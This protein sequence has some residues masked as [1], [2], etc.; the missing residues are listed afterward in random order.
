MIGGRR[1]RG[2]PGQVVQNSLCTLAHVTSDLV[3]HALVAGIQKLRRFV[4]S[5][6]KRRICIMTSLL[7]GLAIFALRHLGSDAVQINP[8]SSV[9][10]VENPAF[11]GHFHVSSALDG[12]RLFRVER[13][14]YFI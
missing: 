9:L 1:Y 3:L 5:N 8:N 10:G 14:I 12:S 11:S 13:N 6:E 7:V 2:P 4:V